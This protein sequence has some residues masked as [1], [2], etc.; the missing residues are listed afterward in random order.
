MLV[1]VLACVLSLY[2]FYIDQNVLYE[3]E[4]LNY[5][6]VVVAVAVVVVVVVE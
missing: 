6:L 4:E 1:V 2:S 3:E 5:V